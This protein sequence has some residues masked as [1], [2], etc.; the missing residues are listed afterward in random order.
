[1]KDALS[2]GVSMKLFLQLCLLA[3][4]ILILISCSTAVIVKSLPAKHNF[5][6]KGPSEISFRF[7][8][9]Q[10]WCKDITCGQVYFVTNEYATTSAFRAS[11]TFNVLSDGATR[12]LIPSRLTQFELYFNFKPE[13]SLPAEMRLAEVALNGRPIALEDQLWEV[14]NLKLHYK[15]L[16]YK[17]EPVFGG[18]LTESILYGGLVYLLCMIA[19]VAFLYRSNS[20]S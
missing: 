5:V 17:P 14:Q 4:E 7:A 13:V 8:E 11:K 15:C 19:A 16:A 18:Y 2:I 20:C 9:G 3:V 12:V 1:M 10:S 6:T